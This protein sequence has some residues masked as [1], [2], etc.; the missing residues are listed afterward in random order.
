MN[1]LFVCNMGMERSPTAVNVALHLGLERKVKVNADYMGIDRDTQYRQ[2][3]LSRLN[4]YDRI[5]VM[6][7]DIGKRLEEEYSVPA[8][9]ITSLNIDDDYDVGDI[10]LK[11][12]IR[13]KLEGFIK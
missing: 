11:T 7:N 5:F 3:V 8:D 9:K 1:L 6:D 10:T 4:E 12:I 13:N 2:A